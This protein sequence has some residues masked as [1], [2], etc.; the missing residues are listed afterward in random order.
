M[1][2]ILGKERD[3]TEFVY[4]EIKLQKLQDLLL[5]FLWVK[6]KEY[7]G[8]YRKYKCRLPTSILGVYFWRLKHKKGKK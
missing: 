3:D 2:N 4:D 7:I 5:F 6:Q 1:F 8:H